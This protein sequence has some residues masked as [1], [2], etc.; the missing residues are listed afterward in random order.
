M[1][2]VTLAHF[3]RNQ[4]PTDGSGADRYRRFIHKYFIAVQVRPEL[5]GN[6]L[7]RRN[8]RAMILVGWGTDGGKYDIG[9]FDRV[10]GIRAE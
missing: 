7:D 10:P 6:V 2:S 8:I 4:L 1:L 9:P 5:P 3:S